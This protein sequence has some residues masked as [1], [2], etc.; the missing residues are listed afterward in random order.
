MNQHT[1]NGEKHES[2]DDRIM[3]G[4]LEKPTIDGHIGRQNAVKAL[5]Q[6]PQYRSPLAGT[7]LEDERAQH[8]CQ[9]ERNE[10]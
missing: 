8:W 3:L 9:R 2:T 7:R 1:Y 6:A 5:P 10:Q 4:K